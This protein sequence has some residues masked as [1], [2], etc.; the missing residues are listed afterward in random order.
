MCVFSFS[1]S[2]LENYVVKLLYYIQYTD[3]DHVHFVG[4]SSDRGISD[5]E[6]F[7]YVIVGIKFQVARCHG[8]RTRAFD[9]LGFTCSTSDPLRQA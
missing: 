3:S 8:N 9:R 7:T 6:D 1:Q 5:S 2:A 4:S